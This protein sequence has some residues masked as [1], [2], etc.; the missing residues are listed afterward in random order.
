MSRRPVPDSERRTHEVRVYLSDEDLALLDKVRGPMTR[1]SYLRWALLCDLEPEPYPEPRV[2]PAF[3][4]TV[5]T[6]GDAPPI[7]IE[8]VRLEP[9]E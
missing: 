5:S 7:D 8:W 6:E 2:F 3:S 9:E 4:A 1:S